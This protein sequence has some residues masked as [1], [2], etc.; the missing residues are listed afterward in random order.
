LIKTNNEPEPN[1]PTVT[2]IGTDGNAFAVLGVCLRAARAA[3]WNQNHID[4]FREQATAGDYNNLLAVV[5]KF[6]DV[7]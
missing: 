7:Q 4:A 6:F 5:Q 3:G 1:R 2:L